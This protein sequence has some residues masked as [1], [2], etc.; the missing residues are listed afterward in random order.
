MTRRERQRSARGASRYR[1]AETERRDLR[2]GDRMGVRPRPGLDLSLPGLRLVP[3]A[4]HQAHV[5]D[6]GVVQQP[7]GVAGLEPR[8]CGI[9]KL[10]AD[11]D[12]GDRSA[13]PRFDVRPEQRGRDIPPWLRGPESS[14]PAPTSSIE[15]GEGASKGEAGFARSGRAR[16]QVKSRKTT[17]AS[18]RWN[19]PSFDA[20]RIGR[21]MAVVLGFIG[22]GAIPSVLYR[23]P[24]ANRA[25]P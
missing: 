20:E 13:H 3:G 18:V 1:R 24:M 23:A 5:L 19:M 17:V 2:P 22:A 15:T 8:I 25:G 7:K 21:A 4:G 9:E 11:D 14:V 16:R 10:L 12:A 6:G